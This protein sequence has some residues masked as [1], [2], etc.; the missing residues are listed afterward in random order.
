MSHRYCGRD[1]QPE[2]IALIRALIAE[3]PT[4]SR[5]A[6]SRFTCQALAWHTANGG[7]KDM[8]AR[9]A[10]LRMHNDGLITL[11]PPRNRRPDARVRL[12]ALSDLQPRLEQPAAELKP[13][14]WSRVQH[15]A[16]SRLWNELIERY[17]YLGHTLLPGAQLRYLVYAAEQPVAAL[18]FGAAA[19]MCAPRDRDIG[20]L[21]RHLL[22]G[23]QLD[24]LGTN[25]RPRKTRP[26]RKT[27]RTHQGHMDLPAGPTLPRSAY[28]LILMGRGRPNIYKTSYTAP[29]AV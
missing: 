19:W 28:P 29:G 12:S 1:F 5:A 8:S 4:R 26:G 27:K 14:T 6:L 11:P 22:Q 13:L 18:G 16:Q 20:W 21:P 2:E 7:L 9:V 24:L 25:Q 15:K 23:R 3:D 17:H 10:M